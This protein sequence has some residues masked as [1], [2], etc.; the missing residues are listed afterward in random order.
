MKTLLI[1]TN[2]RANPSQPSCAARGS[3]ALATE[4]KLAIENEHLAI[5][6]EH[7]DC[8][9]Y[10]DIGINMRLSPNGSFIHEADNSTE[11]KA[12]VLSTVKAIIHQ[13]K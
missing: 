7:T 9:G 2:L 3:H 11:S 10:C 5:T 6:I 1:C 4:L 8:L 12:T 13:D